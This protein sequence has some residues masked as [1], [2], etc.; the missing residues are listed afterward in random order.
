MWLH[1][2]KAFVEAS[3]EHQAQELTSP[4]PLNDDT[5]LTVGKNPDVHYIYVCIKVSSIFIFQ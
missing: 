5:S 3:S 1:V 2:G 4:V